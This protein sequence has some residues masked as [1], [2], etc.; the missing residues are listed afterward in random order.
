MGKG[1]RTR[2]E[3]A[4]A[5]LAAAQTSK[6]VKKTGK[7]MPTWVGTLI[8]VSVVVLLLAITALCVLSARGTFKRMRIIAESEN[9]EV[10]VP[11]MS[12]LIYTEYQN[13]VTMYDQYTSGSG[14]IKIG[15]GEGGDALDRN[16]PLRDQIYS[17]VTGL[18]GQ[19][20]T[21]TWFDYF[22]QIAEK[23]VK[24]ILACCEEARLAG[25]ELS[26]AELAAIEADLNTIASY[27]AMYGYT[28][29]GYLSMMYG[30]G[31]LP[32]DVRNMQKLTQLAS[33]WSSEKANGFLDA[34]TEERINAYYEA[35]KSKYDLFC[36]YVGCT[37]TATFTPSTNTDTDAAA[38]E[39]ATNADTYKAEQEKFAARVTELEGCTT[40]AEFEGKLYN[41]LLE[42]ELAAAAKAKGEE[43]AAGSEAY[44]ECETKARA[45]LT[46]AFATNVKDGDQS[47]DL[48]TWLFEST[49]EGEGDAKKTTYKRK[50]NETKKIESAS[51]VDTAAYAKVTST[52]SAYIF[53][54]GMHANTDPV[55]SV[56]HIL[57][58]SDTFKDLTDSSTLSGKLKELADSVFEKNKDKADFK[59]TALDM[60]YALLD[61]MEA[62]GK[63]TVKTRADGTN[64][65]VIDKA[66]FE[67]Y[68]VY[69][70]DSNVF[71]DDVP[72]G[73]MV[74]E[75]E[76]WMFDASRLEN[77]IT[78]EPVKTSYGYHIMFYVGNEKETWKGEIKNAIADE[79]QKTYLEGVQTTHPTTVKSDYYRYI[80]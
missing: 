43:I 28:T 13:T 25:M 19:T 33:K 66:A 56:G 54:D 46:A 77:E 65:Y 40:R 1:N 52:Y 38:T 3:R 64:Y 60:A 74:A 55:R 18:D 21:T 17:S 70:E 49:T 50:A 9:F 32:K 73:Q 79:E 39:N 31:V 34:V 72:K 62:E 20:V 12:Y 61:K 76:N 10:T 47:G 2:N 8:V 16:L 5:V 29:N 58:K 26:E 69:T 80:G 42:D 45:S 51:N 27:A 6:K 78:D 22:A 59:L 7:G 36:D 41:F 23:D 75:F 67:E 68:G 63:M 71:Y 37:F 53:V 44:R 24:Q 35:N 14:S 48:N 15:G 11:M 4:S 57:F 30:E